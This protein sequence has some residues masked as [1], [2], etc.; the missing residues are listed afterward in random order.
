MIQEFPI[1]V[2]K[3]KKNKDSFFVKTLLLKFFQ[4]LA[5]LSDYT[6]IVEKIFLQK[7]STIVATDVSLIKKYKITLLY[8]LFCERIFKGIT[9]TD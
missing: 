6:H 1:N 8:A 9:K 4:H 2:K 3:N 5:I 7:L